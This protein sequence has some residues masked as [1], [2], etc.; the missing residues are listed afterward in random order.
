MFCRP[1]FIASL[2]S[3]AALG[4]VGASVPAERVPYVKSACRLDDAGIVSPSGLT[5]DSAIRRFAVVDDVRAAV[6]IVGFTCSVESEFSTAVFG[7]DDPQGVTYNSATQH[8]VI[9]DGRAAELYVANS[10]GSFVGSCDLAELGVVDPTDVTYRNGA[11]AYIVTDPTL[12]EAVVVRLGQLGGEPCVQL[13]S[14]DLGEI[15]AT[16]AQAIEYVAALDQYLLGDTAVDKVGLYDTSFSVIDTFDTG[17]GY[18]SA[19]LEGVTYVAF[20]D[21]VYSVD[22]ETKLLTELDINGTAE[23]LCVIGERSVAGFSYIKSTN[24]YIWVNNSTNLAVVADAETCAVDRTLP[25]APSVSDIA[26]VSADNQLAVASNGTVTLLDFDSAVEESVCSLREV[27]L[28]AVSGIDAIDGLGQFVVVD[29]D[30]NAI[31]VIDAECNLLRTASLERNGSQVVARAPDG[32][33]YDSALGRTLVLSGTDRVFVIDSSGRAQT[34]FYR[35]GAGADEGIANLNSGSAFSVLVD[36]IFEH[37]IIRFDVP[38]IPP[39]GSIS[40]SFRSTALGVDVVL[41][42]RGEG[43]VTGAVLLP[44][45]Q[46]PVFGQRTGSRVSLSFETAEGAPGNSSGSVSADLNVLNLS[47]PLGVLTRNLD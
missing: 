24:Q 27:G 16:S 38:R 9:V 22:A 34:D 31:A 29:R 17:V 28:S 1:R 30:A 2:L 13:N 33:G 43:R 12:D 23:D 20:R 5:F 14:F 35:A 10:D 32:V 21:S 7:S 11:D 42:D 6:S 15:G 44:D 18:D 46:L 3:A 25:V 37:A 36:R 4:L 40:G 45:A 26:Y 19:N 8:Y 47:A 39:V 41:F